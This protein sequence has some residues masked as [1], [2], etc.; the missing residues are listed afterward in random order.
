M[1]DPEIP[2]SQGIATGGSPELEDLV[3]Q[4]VLQANLSKKV[5]AFAMVA[6]A[7]Q[8]LAIWF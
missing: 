3:R 5:A 8:L 2:N 7:T 6:A 1:T 4:L